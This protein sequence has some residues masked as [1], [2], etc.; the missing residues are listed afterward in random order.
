MMK[1]KFP[2]ELWLLEAFFPQK[3]INLY[4]FSIIKHVDILFKVKKNTESID[5][6][7]LKSK[8]VDHFYHQKVLHVVVKN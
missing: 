2:L 8:V 3:K 4:P 6:K 7:V 5:S 1:N